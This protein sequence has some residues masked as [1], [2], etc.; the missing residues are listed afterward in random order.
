MNIFKL[1]IV[2][3]TFISHIL[4]GQNNQGKADDASRIALSSV[5]VD[6]INDMS[7]SARNYLKNK[8]G[9]IA[10]K[11]GIGASPLNQRFII[12]ANVQIVES[13]IT[14]GPPEKYL[15]KLEVTFFIGDG[16][17]GKLFASNTF[18]YKGIDQSSTRAY[19]NALKNIRPTDERFKDL[20]KEGKIKIIEYYNAQCDFILK[21]SELLANQNKFEASIAKLSSVPNVCKEC[22]EKCLDQASE[23]YQDFLDR[24]CKILMNKSEAIWASTQNEQGAR[25]A[26]EVLSRID[27][28]SK[29]SIEANNMLNMLYDEM[30]KRILDLD[31]REWE[32]KLKEQMQESERIDAIKQVG[33][34]YGENQPQ[35]VNYNFRG[36]F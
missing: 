26:S 2:F 3:T 21:E 16:I 8:L 24:E 17:D 30:R 28:D 27:P 29:C 9:Q 15:Y 34:A 10:S 5:V 1:L 11:N 20:L 4:I 35:N 6:D 25:E 18:T 22:Y 12:T 33:V 14:P 32:Y 31:K 19:K 23:V 13:N 7:S 36:W